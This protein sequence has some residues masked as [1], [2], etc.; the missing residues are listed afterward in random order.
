MLDP[1]KP[2]LKPRNPV[3]KETGF[4][5]HVLNFSDCYP[6]HHYSDLNP[7]LAVA[8][9]NAKGRGIDNFPVYMNSEAPIISSSAVGRL[10]RELI[11]PVVLSP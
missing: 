11:I 9:F 2:D 3:I 7:L 8:S 5:E 10:S 6:H 1:E 4:L